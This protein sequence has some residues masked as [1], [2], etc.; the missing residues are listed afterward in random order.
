MHAHATIG[1]DLAITSK[2]RACIVTRGKP[3]RTMS[4]SP[5]PAELDA[6]LE[7]AGGPD[8]VDVVLE[9]TGL[10]WVPVAVYAARQ[11]A[12]VYRVDTR[13]AH[14]IR[15]LLSRDVKSDQADASALARTPDIVPGLRPLPPFDGDVFVLARLARTR[16]SLV[17]DRT[18]VI[19]RIKA[20]LQAY[21]PTLAPTLTERSLGG[22]ERV[23]LR[24]FLDPR[25]TLDAG[26]DGL[27]AAVR[28]AGL[29]DRAPK[30]SA[31][32]HAWFEAAEQ[33][34]ALYDG[35]L[36]FAIA[37]RQMQVHLEHFDA[38]GDLI[39]AVEPTWLRSTASSTRA[40][41]TRPCPASERSSAR[42]SAPS[43]AARRRSSRA[44]R[45]PTTW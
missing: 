9:P 8:H 32:I 42:P 37:Q 31:L 24:D 45:A 15:K 17:D 10:T 20:L 40:A 36:P 4:T 28:K 43:W 39:A 5:R 23:L 3:D 25:H 1:L 41:S 19:L 27:H 26:P 29:D 13:Q 16:E 33:T 34:R 6:L 18:E 38:F 21:A 12:C 30:A 11:G 44:S 35:C 2:H 22:V 14:G 7:A